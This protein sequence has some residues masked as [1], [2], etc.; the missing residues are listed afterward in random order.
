[1]SDLPDFYLVYE[2]DGHET[3]FDAESALLVPTATLDDERKQDLE[4][5]D[6]EK[7]FKHGPSFPC[8]RLDR[9]LEILAAHGLLEQIVA[10]CQ[11]ARRE[12]D[13]ENEG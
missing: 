8:F 12:L 3:Y 2:G 7:I 9:I 10:E 11:I 1:M 4:D 6:T 13:E 5:G